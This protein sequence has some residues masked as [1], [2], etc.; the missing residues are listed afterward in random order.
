[1]MAKF[2][3]RDCLLVQRRQVSSR[4]LSF[5]S[6]FRQ[7]S[8]A[9]IVIRQ[10]G[11]FPK[12]GYRSA[13]VAKFPEAN[14]RLRQVFVKWI[15]IQEVILAMVLRSGLLILTKM[16]CYQQVSRIRL[17]SGVGKGS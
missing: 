11:K 10:G 17:S 3:Q 16:G 7:E 15:V 9:W 1:M 14:F 6:V 13:L 2:P 12:A 4:G 5:I 8:L